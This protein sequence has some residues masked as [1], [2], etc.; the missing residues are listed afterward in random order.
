MCYDP[1]SI[2]RSV[3]ATAGLK[4]LQFDHWKILDY[5]LQ[6]DILWWLLLKCCLI[7]LTSMQS[8]R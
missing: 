8:L 4:R 3:M 1:K 5:L 2:A 7:S 6:C